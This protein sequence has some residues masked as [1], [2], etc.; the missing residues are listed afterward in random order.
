MVVVVCSGKDLQKI[1]ALPNSNMEKARAKTILGHD[2]KQ[3]HQAT[4]PK[5]LYNEVS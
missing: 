1:I 5:K 3:T 2:I 4:Q